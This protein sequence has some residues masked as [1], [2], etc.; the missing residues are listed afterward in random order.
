MTNVLLYFTWQTST[1]QGLGHKLGLCREASN[2]TH[3]HEYKQTKPKETYNIIYVEKIN[4]TIYLYLLQWSVC[5]ALC[6]SFPLS[7]PLPLDICNLCAAKERRQQQKPS[8]KLAC[9]QLVQTAESCKQQQRWQPKMET[10]A[11]IPQLP[12]LIDMNKFNA[13]RSILNS[14]AAKQFA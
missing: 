11:A 6:C 12:L 8:D 3:T 4:E 5:C 7:P 13:I 2:K 1:Q 14:K 9:Q 10:Y